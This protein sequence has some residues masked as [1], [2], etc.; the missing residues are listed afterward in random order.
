MGQAWKRMLSSL[1]M[2]YVGA[3]RRIRGNIG[4]DSDVLLW[5]V[6]C[7]TMLTSTC[8]DKTD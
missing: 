5:N 4:Q 2:E 3:V 6:A 8:L 7:S 1:E